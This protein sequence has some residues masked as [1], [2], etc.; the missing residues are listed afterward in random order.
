MD[1]MVV[2]VALLLLK[3]M[4]D[5]GFYTVAVGQRIDF[6]TGMG[7][8]QEDVRRDKELGDRVGERSVVELLKLDAAAVAELR[9]CGFRPTEESRTLREEDLPQKTPGVLVPPTRPARTASAASS[10]LLRHSVSESRRSESSERARSAAVSRNVS[11][12][13]LAPAGPGSVL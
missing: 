11:N 5:A 1:G 10:R 3:G 7:D 12:S 4:A 6:L 8:R 2:E 13:S 9:Y